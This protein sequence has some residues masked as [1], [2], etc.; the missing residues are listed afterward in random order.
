MRIL[1]I[2]DD[3]SISERLLACAAADGHRMQLASCLEDLFRLQDIAGYDLVALDLQFT[4]LD[5]FLYLQ[6]LKNLAGGSEILLLGVDGGNEARARDLG[7]GSRNFLP[8]PPDAIAFFQRAAALIGSASASAPTVSQDAATPPAPPAQTPQDRD[9]APPP[10][11]PG[12]GENP[13]P[14]FSKAAWKAGL[15]NRGR[16]LVVGS[17]KGGT[18]KSTTAM[19]IVTGL[20]YEGLRVASIDLDN[21][22]QTLTRFIE[23]RKA[24]RDAEGLGLPMPRHRSLPFVDDRPDEVEQSVE[25]LARTHDALIVDT[26]GGYSQAARKALTWADCVVTPI[27]D[28]FLD[29]DLLAELDPDSRRLLRPGHY[30]KLIVE[31]RGRRA[32]WQLAPL[33]WLVVR[34]RLSAI[35]AHNKRQ[36]NEALGVLA[37]QL[38][39]RQGPGLGERVIY[40]EHFLQGLTLFDLP[41]EAA[42]GSGKDPQ[43]AA[44]QELRA[45]LGQL[46]P[47]ADGQAAAKLSDAGLAFRQGHAS[48]ALH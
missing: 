42:K 33:D 37:G 21:P 38:G 3:R 8:D 40:R 32:Q 12:T 19:H 23:N 48:A 26:P 11:E 41:V 1:L 27:N 10:H 16:V 22:Q 7:F 13:A 35:D 47:P 29:L 24:H 9:I 20:L 44:R 30:S 6:K 14:L 18:G 25:S 28:S 43:R 15:G 31:A 2:E 34:N 39:F 45:L 36:M 5:P 46:L 4:G 17:H